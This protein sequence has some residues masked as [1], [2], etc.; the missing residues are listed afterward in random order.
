M[1]NRRYSQ[2]WRFL[3]RSWFLLD[4]LFLQWDVTVFFG[5]Y[6]SIVVLLLRAGGGVRHGAT[7]PAAPPVSG[8]GAPVVL[9]INDLVFIPYQYCDW[10][11]DQL[12]DYEILFVI[13]F[14]LYAVDRCSIFRSVIY[15]PHHESVL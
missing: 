11:V 14:E 7:R 6:L 15:G 5:I 1:D 10:E 4:N 12:V 13:V 2:L 8:P 9:I 3:R